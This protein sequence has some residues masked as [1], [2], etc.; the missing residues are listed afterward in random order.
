TRS[1]GARGRTILEEGSACS[2]ASVHSLAHSVTGRSMTTSNDFPLS[3][4]RDSSFV[5]ASRVL[6]ANPLMLMMQSPT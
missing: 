2:S 1:E 3:A 5:T 6:V 4:A